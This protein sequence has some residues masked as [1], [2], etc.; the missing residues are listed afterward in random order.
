[1]CTGGAGATTASKS[2]ADS[3]Q[4][5]RAGALAESGS[6]RKRESES[7]RI[8]VLSASLPGLPE[9]G[10]LTRSRPELSFHGLSLTFPHSQ[11]V[12]LCV[13]VPF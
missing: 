12:C 1:M 10:V 11:C 13:C 6:D 2:W 7:E 9:P 4:A 5:L 3:L 8:Q